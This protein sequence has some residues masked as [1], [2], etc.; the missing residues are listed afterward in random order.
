M[1]NVE[2]ERGGSQFVFGSVFRNIAAHFG[3]TRLLYALGKCCV[4]SVGFGFRLKGRARPIDGME[5]A[6]RQSVTDTLRSM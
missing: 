5:T 2:F 6:I 4:T 3:N 1:G